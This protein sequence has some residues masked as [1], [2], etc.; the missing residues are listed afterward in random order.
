MKHFSW[1]KCKEERSP[2]V[3]DF[4]R[5]NFRKNITEEGFIEEMLKFKKKA[6]KKKNYA[7]CKLA[8]EYHRYKEKFGFFNEE[9]RKTVKENDL[10]NRKIYTLSKESQRKTGLKE[11]DSNYIKKLLLKRQSECHYCDRKLTRLNATIDH[12]IPYSKTQ[13]NHESNLV[14]SC[15][16]CNREKAN[17]T[18][19]EFIEKFS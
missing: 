10:W 9:K 8:S 6:K 5:K 18:P 7:P 19:E 13:N 12:I 2:D 17:K 3:F 4:L 16:Y 11:V 14:L 15:V 1:R